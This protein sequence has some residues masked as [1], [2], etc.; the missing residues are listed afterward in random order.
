MKTHV[1]TFA[2]AAFVATSGLAAAAA[3]KSHQV[4]VN[5]QMV[6]ADPDSFIRGALTKESYPLGD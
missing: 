6:G 1:T 3:P 4:I 5:G 2:L